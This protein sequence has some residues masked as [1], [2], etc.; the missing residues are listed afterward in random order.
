[1]TLEGTTERSQ[2]RSTLLPI[3]SVGDDRLELWHPSLFYLASHQECLARAMDTSV[4]TPA[5]SYSSIPVLFKNSFSRA[6]RLEVQIGEC[7][8]CL[9]QGHVDVVFGESVKPSSADFVHLPLDKARHSRRLG[10]D[11]ESAAA[12]LL[13]CCCCSSTCCLPSTE[14]S[15][16][17]IP[18]LK[19]LNYWR[20]ENTPAFT[21]FRTQR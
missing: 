20:P 11:H 2:Q 19:Y 17:N 10:A 18:P 5:F 16:V 21:A 15:H 3:G 14:P 7:Y 12:L 4:G 6:H 8:L 9:Q 13:C 1:M